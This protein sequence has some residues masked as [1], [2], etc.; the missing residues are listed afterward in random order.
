MYAMLALS[1]KTD[2]ALMALSVLARRERGVISAREVAAD[3]G[4]PLSILTNIL[5][6]LVRAGIIV[7]ERGAYGGYS[8][9]GSPDTI[10]RGSC[11]RPGPLPGP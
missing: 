6:N 3:S 11:L 7:S 8:L 4:A 9:A 10:T 2:Y 1:R 5:K